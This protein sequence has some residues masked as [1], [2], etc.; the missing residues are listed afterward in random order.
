MSVDFLNKQ[1]NFEGSIM[2]N[3]QMINSLVRQGYKPKVSEVSSVKFNR[4]KYNQMDG[5]EQEEY[6][7]KLNKTKKEYSAENSEGYSY[8]LSKKGYDYMLTLV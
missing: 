7:K 1:V 5:Y 2:S 6:E 8:K 3:R 4:R